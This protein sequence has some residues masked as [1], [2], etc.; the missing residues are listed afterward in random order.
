MKEAAHWRSDINA[1]VFTI[2]PHAAM[3]AVHFGAFRT[4]LGFEPAPDDCV[5][6][7]Q[8]FEV[9]FRSAANGKIAR[10]A[11]PAGTNLHLT[12]RDIAKMLLESGQTETG[13]RR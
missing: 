12:S 2:E 6:Y 8:K 7:F 10:K 9:A 13:V 11:I 4:L 1:L 3:C 5:A